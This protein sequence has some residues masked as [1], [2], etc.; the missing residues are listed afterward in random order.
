[1]KILILLLLLLFI[2]ILQNKQF[3]DQKHLLTEKNSFFR[4]ELCGKCYLE[5]DF[6]LLLHDK[7][8]KNCLIVQKN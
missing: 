2:W 6:E 7:Y 5:M 8:Y 4:S 3:K 1:M